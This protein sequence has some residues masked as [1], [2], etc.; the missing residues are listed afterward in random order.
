MVPPDGYLSTAISLK[1]A[2]FPIPIDP[3]H[4]PSDNSPMSIDTLSTD[5]RELQEVCDQL[6][7]GVRDP[8]AAKE[9][10]ERLDRGRE[11]LRKRIG[12]VD[13]AVD[14][15]RDARDQ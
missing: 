10:A 2:C 12:V 3:R 1:T 15:I 9:A 14:L 6:S 7:K 4:P 11:E 8:K 5:L 13:M